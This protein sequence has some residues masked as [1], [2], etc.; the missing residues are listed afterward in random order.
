[1]MPPKKAKN[2]LAKTVDDVVFD[3]VAG[4][5]KIESTSKAY[6]RTLDLLAPFVK[7]VDWVI[8]GFMANLNDE[9][10][11]KF[12]GTILQVKGRSPSLRKTTLAAINWQ[13][14]VKL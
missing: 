7:D 3:E 10:L 11:A 1:M 2:V 4:N 8:G 13:L 14:Q 9:N 5:L 12:V 6:S